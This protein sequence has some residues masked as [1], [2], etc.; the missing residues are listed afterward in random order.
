MD[1]LMA[2]KKKQNFYIIEDAC[3]SDGGSYHG[4]RLGTIGDCGAFSFNYFK[5][6][7]CGEGGALVTH[8]INVF[9][10]AIIYH[11][12]GTAFW[13]YEQPITEP[14]VTGVNMRVGEVN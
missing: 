8:D 4:K 1:G 9:Q 2:L 6:I 11:D 3:Q 5:I 13:S 7:S 12:C 10:R 14:L